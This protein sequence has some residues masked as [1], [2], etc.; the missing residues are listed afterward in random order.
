MHNSNVTQ[1]LKGNVYA[2]LGI[3]LSVAPTFF[4]SSS[5]ISSSLEY[6]NSDTSDQQGHVFLGL[7][8]R[9]S[10]LSILGK[11]SREKL[12]KHRSHLVDFLSFKG[13]IN[14]NFYMPCDCSPVPSERLIFVLR[15]FLV[16]TFSLLSACSLIKYKLLHN[17]WNWK[18]H[19]FCL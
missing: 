5:K 8:S 12:Y 16:S 14:S 3:F 11:P 15:D 7:S 17:Y 2:D 19:S 10:A 9:Q 6:S 13:W 4:A 18:S 1:G